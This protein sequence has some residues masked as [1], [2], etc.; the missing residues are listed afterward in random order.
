M[1]K[2]LTETDLQELCAQHNV[3]YI[4]IE[5]LQNKSG[6]KTERY[7]KFIC[8]EHEQFGEQ[9]RKIYDFRRQKCICKYCN[10]TELKKIFKDEVAK[11]NDTIEVLSEYKTWYEKV[12]CKCK[13][14]GEEWLARPSVIL[15]GGGCAKCGREKAN[16][17]EMVSQ[18]EIEERITVRN[19]NIKVIGKY[20]GY[21]KPIRCL[22][23]ID[24]TEWE[25]NVCNLIGGYAGCPTCNKDRISKKFA[26]SDDEF[27]QRVKNT[28]PDL[29]VIGK[30]V[31]AHT[32]IKIRCN[33]HNYE[34][35]ANPSSIL[36]SNSVA[37]PLCN[38]TRGEMK[39][40]N[41]LKKYGYNV[42]LQYTFDDCEYKRKLRFDAYD[43]E[44]NIAFEYQGEQHYFPVDFAGYGNEWAEEQFEL[45]QKR[46][47]VKEEYCERN[48][49][50]LVKIPYWN[51]DDMEYF[52]LQELE[53]V[54]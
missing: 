32:P 34:F 15:Y 26:L 11:V 44:N 43:K 8:E 45:N 50:P 13:I 12:K 14:C 46:D 48:N 10:H 40:N 37:C 25:S 33:I 2:K 19:K 38:Q 53:K 27:I 39:M 20:Y 41:V 16:I 30:Y 42:E 22:C 51:Y 9:V 7:I 23:L 54:I 52:L 3:K 4:G 1:K 18:E 21:H 24:G 6:T 49:I 29:T 31:N 47:K 35:F 17:S 5:S 28:N 36:Y